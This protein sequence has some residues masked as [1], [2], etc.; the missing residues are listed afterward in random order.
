M[1]ETIVTDLKTA[2]RHALAAKLLGDYAKLEVA[3]AKELTETLM[4]EVG[5][6]RVRVVDDGGDD[7]GTLTFTKGPATA[8]VSDMGALMDWVQL[9][10]P[11]RIKTV[12]S[13]VVD[14]EWLSRTL[15]TAKS[16]GIAVDSETGEV[17][18]GITVERPAPHLTTRAT[19]VARERMTELLAASGVLALDGTP[20]KELA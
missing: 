7:L 2:A 12:T 18:P 4:S 20:H 6:D 16:L 15:S 10:H 3:L 9:R 17:V 14:G 11:E 8:R 1:G 5:A 19:P 13:T